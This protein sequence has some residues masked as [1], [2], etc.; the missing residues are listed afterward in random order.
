MYA[1][2]VQTKKNKWCIKVPTI[3]K[4]NFSK[5]WSQ[6]YKAPDL[7]YILHK[8]YV[9]RYIVYLQNAI[10]WVYC[11][12][13]PPLTPFYVD[14]M[15]IYTIQFLLS[16]KSTSYFTFKLR[17]TYLNQTLKCSAKRIP[18]SIHFCD[19]IRVC[20]HLTICDQVYRSTL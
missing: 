11:A 4:V 13:F 18:L 5:I 2:K 12:L 15:N 1:L 7:P 16:I 3:P 6:V 14:Q 17:T 9:G 19:V 8:T 10:A 20:V